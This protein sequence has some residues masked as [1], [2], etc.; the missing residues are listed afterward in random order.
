MVGEK[1]C[2]SVVAPFAIL[3]SLTYEQKD[4]SPTGVILY[5]KLQFITP[6]LDLNFAPLLV[7]LNWASQAEISGAHILFRLSSSSWSSKPH[8]IAQKKGIGGTNEGTTVRE[9]RRGESAA[10]R[11]SSLCE[12]SLSDRGLSILP[13]LCHVCVLLWVTLVREEE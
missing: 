12:S 8:Q 6:R 11:A 7:S 2:G 4:A 13:S 5:E 9:K 10:R 1:S 3:Y